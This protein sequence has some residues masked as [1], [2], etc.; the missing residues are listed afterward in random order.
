[1]SY[2]MPGYLI[3]LFL[4]SCTTAKT[5]QHVWPK[6]PSQLSEAEKQET[7]LKFE[8]QDWS[9]IDGSH[10]YMGGTT[11]D[12]LFT[13]ESLRPSMEQIAPYLK[14]DLESVA[15]LHQTGTYMLYGAGG[16]FGIAAAG[17]YAEQSQLYHYSQSLGLLSLFI[18]VIIEQFEWQL[19]DQ[20]QFQFNNS[21][22][23]KLQIFDESELEEIDL[24]FKAH[25]HSQILLGLQWQVQP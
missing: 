3:M 12:H 21:L 24:G 19:K 1:M 6:Q 4:V 9:G 13:L 25:H 22:R 8:I 7:L 18:W 23:D 11:S 14:Q 20:I 10:F 2:A 16:L 15:S 17:Y 5:F